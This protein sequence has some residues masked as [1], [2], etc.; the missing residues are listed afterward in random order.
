[1]RVSAVM[2]NTL[3]LPDASQY[4]YDIIEKYI[5]Q[6]LSSFGVLNYGAEG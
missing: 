4:F 3:K 2:I 6:G 1:M 5:H